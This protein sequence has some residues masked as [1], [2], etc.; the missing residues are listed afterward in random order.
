MESFKNQGNENGEIL[1]QVYLEISQFNE[2]I[3]NKMMNLQFEDFNN[4]MD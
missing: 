1:S 4:E 2:N 3:S